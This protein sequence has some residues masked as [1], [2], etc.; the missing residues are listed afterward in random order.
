MIKIIPVSK[1][2]LFIIIAVF[3]NDYYHYYLND[4]I[5]NKNADVG[6]WRIKY[7]DY[8]IPE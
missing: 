4:F 3:K 5:K 7:K 2:P 8:A 6:V 1:K